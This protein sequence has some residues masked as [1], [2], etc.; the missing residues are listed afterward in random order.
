MPT[1]DEQLKGRLRE[2]APSPAVA[3][4]L[5]VR[6]EGRKRR[7]ATTRKFGT[8]GLVAAVLLGTAGG[9]LILGRAFD[10]QTKPATTPTVGSGALVVSASNEDSFFLYV[11]PPQN[12]DLDPSD[13]ARVADKEQ[14]RLLA[15][16]GA[17]RDTQPAVS[18]DGSTVAFEHHDFERPAALWLVG[19]D[20]SDEHSV[21]RA[22]AD[23]Q[24]PAWS[25]D[26]SSIAFSAADEPTGRALYTIAPD[27]SDLRLLARNQ[28]VGAP[29]WSPDGSRIVFPAATSGDGLGDLWIVS[30]DGSGLHN[31]TRT[32]DVA[33]SDPAWS[34]DGSTIAFVT[35]S[36]IEQMPAAGG[37]SQ[38]IIP[39]SPLGEGRVPTAPAW[40]PDGSY[41]T[42][43]LAAPPPLST[44]TIY[45]LPEGGS[46]AFPLAVGASFA[47]QPVP[48]GTS[49]TP[50]PNDP[51]GVGMSTCREQT[52]P[53][54][55]AGVAGN[56]YVFTQ[57]AGGWPKP[58]EGKRF[59]AADLDGDGIADTSPVEVTGCF[60]PVGCETFAAPDVNGDGT[61]EIAVSNAGADGYGVQLF[62]ITTS[63]PAIVPI[64]VVDPQG[65]GHIQTGRFEFAWVDVAGHGE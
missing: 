22:P 45:V 38:V 33:E 62:A 58:G 28:D 40:T 65:I 37:A 17:A 6:L 59:V 29:A 15:G 27:G 57:E 60:P 4:E 43:I 31:L 21:T 14:M 18:P 35:S 56:A 42:F 11:L 12:Q 41:L 7:R 52:M 46:D 50:P 30:P 51:L 1:I 19:I 5:F 48:P 23:V 26:G 63:P 24:G 2:A 16:T 9:F 54:T 3:D 13:G 39:V 36:G 10:D 20:G 34:P 49:A 8:V 32:P 44:S 64:D 55:V 25:P 53:I 47:W 61:S